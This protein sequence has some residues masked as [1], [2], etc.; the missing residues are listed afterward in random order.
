MVVVDGQRAIVGGLC[1]GDEWIGDPEKGLLPWRDT[2]V[3]SQARR[4]R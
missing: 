2:A 3:R 4:P 1:I